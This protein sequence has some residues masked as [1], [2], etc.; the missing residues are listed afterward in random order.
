MGADP[1]V[2]AGAGVGQGLADG[3]GAFGV[4]GRQVPCARGPMGVEG[5]PVARGSWCLLRG[6]GGA[7]GG[8]ERGARVAL[9]GLVPT[10]GSGCGPSWVHAKFPG[11][12]APNVADGPRGGRARMPPVPACSRRPHITASPYRRVT[13]WPY[14]HSRRVDFRPVRVTTVGCHA[15]GTGRPRTPCGAAGTQPEPARSSG[16]G[17]ANSTDEAEATTGLTPAVVAGLVAS[18]AILPRSRWL[19]RLPAPQWHPSVQAAPSRSG[20]PGVA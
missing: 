17:D 12:T 14:G 8:E 3:S 1:G 20:G 13:A 11:G 18:A 7:G 5:A 6:V 4:V 9:D 16:Q 19:L 10:T 2:M 15:S